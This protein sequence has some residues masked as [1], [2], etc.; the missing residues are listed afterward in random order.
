MTFDGQM[1]GKVSVIDENGIPIPRKNLELEV[2]GRHSGD[3]KA[4]WVCKIKYSEEGIS[5]EFYCEGELVG[6]KLQNYWE[7]EGF[8]EHL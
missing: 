1:L 8:I 3:T 7:I 5:Y 4:L 2:E 6:V